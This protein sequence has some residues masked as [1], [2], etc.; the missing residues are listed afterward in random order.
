MSDT[1]ETT[2]TT[3]VTDTAPVAPVVP[4]PPVVPATPPVVVT[5]PPAPAAAPTVDVQK[6]IQ[7]PAIQEQLRLAAEAAFKKGQEAAKEEADKAAAR[8]KMEETERLKLEKQEADDKAA[9][10]ERTLNKTK[11]E[12][13]VARTLADGNIQLEDPAKS[14]AF[15]EFKVDEYLRQNPTATTE[16]A[17]LAVLAENPYLIKKG[18]ASAAAVSTTIVAPTTTVTTTNAQPAPVTVDVLSMSKAEYDAYKRKQ[19]GVG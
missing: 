19:H 9:A 12:L 8:A 11:V 6:L 10:A 15:V 1:Q 14:R 16:A 18:E 5:P 4:P 3:T 2:T 7:S 17:A 13:G